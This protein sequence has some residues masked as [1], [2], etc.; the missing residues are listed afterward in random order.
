MPAYPLGLTVKILPVCGKVVRQVRVAGRLLQ[1]APQV[2]RDS[3]W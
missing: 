3:C 2:A 1:L